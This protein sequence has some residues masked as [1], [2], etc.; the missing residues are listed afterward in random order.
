MAVFS[1][2]QDLLVL[3]T[4]ISLLMWGLIGTPLLTIMGDEDDMLLVGG[5]MELSSRNFSDDSSITDAPDLPYENS[6]ANDRDYFPHG[7]FSDCSPVILTFENTKVKNS[8]TQRSIFSQSSFAI[9]FD[10]IDTQKC[11]DLQR[12]VM[13]VASRQD[14]TRMVYDKELKCVKFR[15]DHS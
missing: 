5:W 12:E 7:N 3:N 14:L 10:F 1:F 11:N 15:S 6:R 4:I 2:I 8:G 9:V 13:P